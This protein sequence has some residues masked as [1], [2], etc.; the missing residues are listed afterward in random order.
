MIETS[1]KVAETFELRPLGN[2]ALFSSYNAFG[3]PF[4]FVLLILFSI[5]LFIICEGL[6]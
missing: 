5:P 6:I 1:N 4:L 3:F 2:V